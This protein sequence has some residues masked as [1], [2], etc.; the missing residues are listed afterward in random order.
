M[1]LLFIFHRR[2]Q[3]HGG[4]PEGHAGLAQAQRL[5]GTR[6]T[7]ELR[8]VRFPE[9]HRR[10]LFDLNDFDEILAWAASSGT[11]RGLREFTIV[12]ATTDIEGRRARGGEGVGD[13][14]REAMADFAKMLMMDIWYSYLDEDDLMATL[15]SMSWSRR[16]KEI[17]ARRGRK[18]KQDGGAGEA[19][20][21]A[22]KAATADR[23]EGAAPGTA[24]RRC[25]S[26][27]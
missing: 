2:R 23:C 10:L 14:H 8:P 5:C 11:G 7:V 26:S 19:G 1:V 6:S 17:R 25:S 9:N 15:L 18:G 24:C 13:G 27:G 21:R 20:Q 16:E 3:D 4:G 22:Q 12:A